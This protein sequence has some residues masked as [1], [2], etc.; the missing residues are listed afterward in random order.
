[1][2][3][4]NKGPATAVIP[5]E[6]TLK[7]RMLN[8]IGSSRLVDV[9]TQRNHAFVGCDLLHQTRTPLGKS[10]IFDDLSAFEEQL[11]ER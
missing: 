9:K 6:S 10:A 7:E 8:K 4:R 5:S 3:R 11:A 1:L 2:S